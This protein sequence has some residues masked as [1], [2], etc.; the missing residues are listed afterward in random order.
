MRASIY[1]S[2][3]LTTM[4]FSANMVTA[5]SFA[6]GAVVATT[7]YDEVNDFEIIP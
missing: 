1:L 3:F 5:L 2:R 6:K 7:S 4:G